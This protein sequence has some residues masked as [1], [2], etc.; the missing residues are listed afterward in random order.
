MN[1]ELYDVR[2][3]LLAIARKEADLL[4]GELAYERHKSDRLTLLLQEANK[5]LKALFYKDY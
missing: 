4:R 1:E 3:E 5:K 2:D